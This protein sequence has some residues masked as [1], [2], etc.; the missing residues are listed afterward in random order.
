MYKK[1]LQYL[2]LP[3]SKVSSIDKAYRKYNLDKAQKILNKF[4]SDNIT[5]FL[6]QGSV[7]RDSV[8]FPLSDLDIICVVKNKKL[9]KQQF[10]KEN[11]SNF[12]PVDFDIYSE[13]EF[14]FLLK[15]G[16][17]RFYEEKLI[18][19]KGQVDF[20]Y[21]YIPLKFYFDV[22]VEIFKKIEWINIFL[23]NENRLNC[24]R[25]EHLYR[26]INYLLAEIGIKEVSI[27]KKEEIG[28]LG[29]S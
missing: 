19:L 20:N 25:V 8:K 14:E 12:I 26:N 13:D 21:Y 24:A 9:F 27:N 11:K 22:T 4:D 16:G 23:K 18:A 5:H 6:I 7:A 28:Y 15:F 3:L 17:Y 1:L 29:F 10:E 2:A